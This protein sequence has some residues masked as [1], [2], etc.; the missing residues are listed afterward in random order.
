VVAGAVGTVA[1]VPAAPRSTF[2]RR[3]Q[4]VSIL[5]VMLVLALGFSAIPAAAEDATITRKARLSQEH[6]ASIDLATWRASK[7][8]HDISWRESHDQCHVVSSD[9]SYRGKWQMSRS[10]WRAYGGRKFARTPERATCKEQD[11]IARRVWIAQWW[12]PWGG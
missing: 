12:W 9:G 11:R 6:R 1:R 8:G 5:T 2:S 10:L 3:W 7:H 4:Q